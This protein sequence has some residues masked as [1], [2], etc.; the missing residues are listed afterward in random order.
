MELHHLAFEVSNLER[1]IAWYAETFGMKLQFQ[2]TDPA[3]GESFAILSFGTG[4]LELLQ[5]IGSPV[6]FRKPEIAPPY[7]PHLAFKTEDLDGQV[8]ELVAR[9]V[10]VAAGPFENGPIRWVYVADLD[11]NVIEFIQERRA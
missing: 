11:N 1:S 8:R 4:A 9:G 3:H 6:P 5:R 7:C 10:V 2:A